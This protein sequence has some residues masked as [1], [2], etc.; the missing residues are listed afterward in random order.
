MKLCL[1]VVLLCSVASTAFGQFAYVNAH[2]D[3]RNEGSLTAARMT[4]TEA[5]HLGTYSSR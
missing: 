3:E 2:A 5:I 1:L 4:K